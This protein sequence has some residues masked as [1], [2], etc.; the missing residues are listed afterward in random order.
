[1]RR[2]GATLER[3]AV[4]A[5]QEA[6]LETD[7]DVVPRQPRGHRAR[8]E[9]RRDVDAGERPRP[10][11]AVEDFVPA[12]EPTA[13]APGVL[14]HV[15]EPAI[16][17]REH[18]FNERDPAVVMLQAEPSPGLDRPHGRAQDALLAPDLGLVVLRAPLQRRVWLRH[19]RAHADRD[20]GA[21]ADEPA[22]DPQH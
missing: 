20:L 12:V 15:G 6:V 4:L 1:A 10:A 5:E 3:L 9:V 2:A 22:A 13:V 7:V 18:A 16:A 17:P 11:L 21:P 14:G 19:V 8:A